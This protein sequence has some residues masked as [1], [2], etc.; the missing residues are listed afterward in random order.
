V[1]SLSDINGD[2][3]RSI[4]L[5]LLGEFPDRRIF[6]SSNSQEDYRFFETRGE[7]RIFHHPKPSLDRTQ[8]DSQKD[9]LADML[10]LA[11]TSLLV[12][13]RNSS[14]AYI[15]GLARRVPQ[16]VLQ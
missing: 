1:G 13:H 15:S 6:L 14:F 9:A 8:A 12:R 2:Q 7:G 11:R 10:L 16:L 3:W 5:R 4:C